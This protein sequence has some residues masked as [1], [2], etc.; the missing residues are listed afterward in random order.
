MQN[1]PVTTTVGFC[2]DR[3]PMLHGYLSKRSLMA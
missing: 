3:S 2:V 1:I